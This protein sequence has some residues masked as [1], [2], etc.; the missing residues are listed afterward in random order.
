MLDKNILGLSIRFVRL[1]WALVKNDGP[2]HHMRDMRP[3]IQVWWRGRVVGVGVW[4]DF[5]L[6]N[7]KDAI[8]CILGTLRKIISM[9]EKE[10]FYIIFL[11]GLSFLDGP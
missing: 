3:F 11:L 1:I 9:P 5:E 7:A 2:S 8:S 4:E 10:D 6:S